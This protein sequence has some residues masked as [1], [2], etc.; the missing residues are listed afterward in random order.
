VADEE[1]DLHSTKQGKQLPSDDKLD[2]LK[3]FCL[4]T[5]P[6]DA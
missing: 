1:H 6:S 5:H 4:H 3:K 2:L